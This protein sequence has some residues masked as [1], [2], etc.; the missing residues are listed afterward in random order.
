MFID[1]INLQIFHTAAPLLL[2]FIHTGFT[3][4]FKQQKTLGGEDMAYSLT[5]YGHLCNTTVIVF[6]TI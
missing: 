1:R 5:I 2:H 6:Q 3:I 4:A